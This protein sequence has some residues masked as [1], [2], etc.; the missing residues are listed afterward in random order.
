MEK[1]TYGYIRQL[2]F[3]EE[4]YYNKFAICEELLQG[5]T[6][7]KPTVNRSGSFFVLVAMANNSFF[8]CCTKFRVNI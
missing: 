2:E 4:S 8:E 3:V 7:A 6:R 5:S 1:G